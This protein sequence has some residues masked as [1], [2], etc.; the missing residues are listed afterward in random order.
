[1]AAARELLLPYPKWPPGEATARPALPERKM[2]PG[3]GGQRP[4]GARGKASHVVRGWPMAG[5][6][7]G[8]VAG[9]WGHRRAAPGA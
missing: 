3:G 1:M 5:E 7:E 8:A 9:R 4:D 6:E 2:A